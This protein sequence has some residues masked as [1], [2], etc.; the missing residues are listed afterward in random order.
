MT[1]MYFVCLWSTYVICVQWV[2]IWHGC[3]LYVYDLCLYMYVCAH[4]CG[5]TCTT[6]LVWRS[7]DNFPDQS[8]PPTLFGLGSLMTHC[9]K[10]QAGCPVFLSILASASPPLPC[11]IEPKDH[12]CELL[13]WILCVFWGSTPKSWG[14]NSKCFGH[15]AI[16]PALLKRVLMPHMW[17]S[18]KHT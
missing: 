10:N 14:L 7:G 8:L 16:S 2:H 11:D 17:K 13:C 6:A 4:E 1:C 12:R 18:R 15:R 9:H 5:H 3:I